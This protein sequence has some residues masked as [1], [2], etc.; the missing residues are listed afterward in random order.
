[1]VIKQCHDSVAGAIKQTRTAHV[2][3]IKRQAR[4]IVGASGPSAA[5]LLNPAVAIENRPSPA[6]LDRQDDVEGNEIEAEGGRVDP[7]GQEEPAPLAASTVKIDDTS[8][9]RPKD[10]SSIRLS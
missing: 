1:M 5:I 3:Q 7:A 4:T 8:T 6:P 9:H 10:N 2:D